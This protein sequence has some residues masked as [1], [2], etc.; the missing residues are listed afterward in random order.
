M[1]RPLVSKANGRSKIAGLPPEARQAIETW[2]FDENRSYNTVIRNCREKWNAS[3]NIQNLSK[4]YHKRLR[5][6]ALR[7]I[8]NSA[9][10]ANDLIAEFKKFPAETYDVLIKLVGQ[11][12]F[13]SA[14]KSDGG[15]DAGTIKDFTR[16]LI[17]ARKEDRE[18]RQLTFT[19]EKWEFDAARACRAHY[20]EIRAVTEDISLEEE[21]KIA[22]IRRR[23]FGTNLPD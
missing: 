5:E 21:A 14:L 15:L 20:A 11:I 6:R 22:A 10:L 19:R 1:T 16:L 8:G 23:L 12:A 7:R 4:Y 2:L 9:C 3:L 17:A 13:D 18:A